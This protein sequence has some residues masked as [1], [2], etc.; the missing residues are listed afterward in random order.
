MICDRVAIIV[1]GKIRYEGRIHDFL[2]EEAMRSDIVISSLSPDAAE[3]IEQQVGAQFSGVADHVEIQVSDKD[4]TTVL[5]RVLADGADVISV[6]KHRASLENIFL[7]AVERSE[8][9]DVEGGIR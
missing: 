4:V 6:T 8:T 1:T 3:R 2:G 5:E 9:T 7:E